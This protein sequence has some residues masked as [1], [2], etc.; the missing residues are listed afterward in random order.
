MFDILYI[1]P[2]SFIIVMEGVIKI[3]IELKKPNRFKDMLHK[4]CSKLEDMMFSILLKLPERMIPSFL[5][6]QIE[7]YINKQIS[8][9]KQEI[10]KD[11]WKQ[12]ALNEVLDKANRK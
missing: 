7:K 11:R 3:H 6:D 8:K 10:I 9:T 4:I 12:V 2:I 5:I 1:F